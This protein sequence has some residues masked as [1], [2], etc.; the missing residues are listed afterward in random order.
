MTYR[1]TITQNGA[2]K[3]ENVPYAVDQLRTVIDNAHDIPKEDVITIDH[4]TYG[5]VTTR[6]NGKWA[7]NK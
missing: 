6:K 5:T 1:Y 2:V 4:P 3:A 7:I